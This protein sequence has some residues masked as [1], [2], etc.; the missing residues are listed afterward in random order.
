MIRC[1]L[2]VS[3]FL[4]LNAAGTAHAIELWEAHLPGLDAG[5][6]AGALPPPGLYGAISTYW[7]SNTKYDNAGNKTPIKLDALVVVPVLLWSTGVTVLGGKYAVA[8]SQPFDCTN[9]TL[10]S[11]PSA[12]SNAHWGRFNTVVAPA[13][14]SWDLTP[15]TSIK[16]GLFYLFDNASSSPAK[17]PS[18]GGVGSGNGHDSWMPELGITTTVGSWQLNAD[19]MYSVNGRN[20]TTGYKSGDLFQTDFSAI[21]RSGAFS[22]GVGGFSV[23][24]VTRDS[25]PLPADCAS[26]GCKRHRFALG[27]LVTYQAGPALLS[28]QYHKDLDT[29][30]GTGGDIVNLRI[31]FPF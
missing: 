7:A 18:G 29:R 19:L 10:P 21:Y 27:P 13:L 11:G 5:L 26:S 6:P 16:A 23:Y 20:N 9:L 8:L 24:Q 2:I 22:L 12:A 3:A 28:A 15:Q 17:P 4:S 14:I 30:N 25:G 31:V 1:T